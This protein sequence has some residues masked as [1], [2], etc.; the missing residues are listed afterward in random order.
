MPDIK[1]TNLVKFYALCL[2]HEKPHHGYELIKF[3]SSKLGKTAS[4]GE[5]YPFLNRLEKSHYIKSYKKGARDKT[6]YHLTPAGRKFVKK[7][8]NRFGS[9]IELAIEPKLSSCAHC[10]CKVYGKA[11]REKIKNKSLVFCC[12]HCANSYKKEV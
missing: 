6:T 7:L 11:H 3:I 8:I 10:G 2:L 12:C 1:V 5:I 4:P 9:L